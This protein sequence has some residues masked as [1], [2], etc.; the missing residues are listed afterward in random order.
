M[1]MKD[2]FGH[3]AG[4]AGSKSIT[5]PWDWSSISASRA[6]GHVVMFDSAEKLIT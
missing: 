1:P 2:P 6:K 4:K 5:S 3:A